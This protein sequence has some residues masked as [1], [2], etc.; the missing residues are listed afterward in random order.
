MQGLIGCAKVK[1]NILKS[2]MNKLFFNLGNHPTISVAELSKVFPNNN[3]SEVLSSEIFLI[4][5]PEQIDA[6]KLIK[7]LGGTIKIGLIKE[8]L[9]DLSFDK[10]L[11]AS[12]KIIDE[13]KIDTKYHFGISIHG[14]IKINLKKLG[15]EIKKH[16][17]EKDK[18]C[19]WVSGKENVLSSVI[20]EQNKLIRS[21]V[22]I[23]IFGDK[24]TNEFYIGRTL[25]V[26]PFKELSKRDYGRPAR[27]DRSG[28]LPP[29]LAQI[30]INLALT[31]KKE[32]LL[33]PFCGSGTVLSEAMLMGYINLIGS[34][35]SKKA[36]DDTR[37]NLS[38]MRKKFL[39]DNTDCPLYELSA[40]NISS[41]IKP[42]SVG[43]I[44]T[45]PYLG[46][47]RG[48]IDIKKTIKD[49]EKL[50][51]DSLSEF[52]K[53]LK[54][55]GRIAIILPAFYVNPKLNFIHPNFN[56]FKIINPLPEYLQGNSFLQLT[57]RQTM[58][59][60][61]QGQKVWREIVILEK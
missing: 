18:S 23:V 46:P 14:Q 50:Y 54:P 22:E 48:K 31:D 2:T 47:Q 32:V 9:T 36:I 57:P 39:L 37:V 3:T 28:M 13:K 11:Q 4:D 33:D 8:K 30:I 26:Q 10:V 34:D 20:V 40:V 45:E 58:I 1:A 24:K 21:G 15:M 44:A 7:N 16:L 59:Y 53:I 5:S 52:K 17:K 35:I 27:D 49:L 41:K 6:T 42:N 51:S 60:K 43:A 55:D 12:I 38:W 61:R 56:D 25:A 29:K 19:R